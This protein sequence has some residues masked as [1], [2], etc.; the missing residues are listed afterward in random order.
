[1]IENRKASYE[2]ELLEKY[3]AGIKLKG[4]EVKDIRLGV[5]NLNNSYVIFKN[6]KPYILN[7][8]IYQN[9]DT[10]ELLLHKNE[11]L[12]LQQA[13]KLKGLSLVV[14]KGYFKRNLFKIEFYLARGKN[15]HDKRESIKKRDLE[16]QNK[17]GY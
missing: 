6:N 4:H 15:L 7:M 12:K 1:M 11:I 9:N 14:T 2:Y 3:E 16:R 13:V 8:T 17:E 10:R 5:C